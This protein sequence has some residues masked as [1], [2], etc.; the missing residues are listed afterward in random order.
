VLL[1]DTHPVRTIAEEIKIA[2]GPSLV[3]KSSF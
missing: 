2:N 3:F 1:T